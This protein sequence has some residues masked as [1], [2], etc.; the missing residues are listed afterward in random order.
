VYRELKILLVLT[1]IYCIG[2]CS[3]TRYITDKKSVQLQ[4]QMHAHRSGVK[5]GD[6]LLNTASF[7][8]SVTLG[9]AME[10]TASERAFKHITIENETVDSMTVNMVTDIEWKDSQ[11]C[12][13]MG[14][15]LPP[16]ASQKLLVPFP[17]A[18]NIYFR[19][20]FTEEDTLSIRTDNKKNIYKLKPKEP[21]PSEE[22]N[23]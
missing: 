2:G 14:I 11:Y 8:M 12:D 17:A 22:L 18:Y 15:V 13:I 3:N 9:S 10:F 23:K 7:I 16:K 19:T 4:H 21:T 1:A 5:A 6:I 20:P